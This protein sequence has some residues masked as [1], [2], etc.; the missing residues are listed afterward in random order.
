MIHPPFSRLRSAT[1]RLRP[2]LWRAGDAPAVWDVL[3]LQPST[4]SARAAWLAG[5]RF[6]RKR[7]C[8]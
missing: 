8:C 1:L 3:S 2:G 6:F 5:S 4:P 7:C